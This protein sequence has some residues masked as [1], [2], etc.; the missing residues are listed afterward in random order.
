[1]AKGVVGRS[2]D[3][4]DALLREVCDEIVAVAND[5]SYFHQWKPTDMVVWDNWRVL[6]SVSGMPPEHPRC[7]HRT[8]IAGD[9]GLGRFETTDETPAGS[10]T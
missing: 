10:G 9:Y 1:M 5:L 7:M 3:E 2:A 4:G 6:H 8:T